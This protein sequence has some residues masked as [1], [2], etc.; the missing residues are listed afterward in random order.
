M[1]K[2]RRQSQPVVAMCADT[3]TPERTHEV[4]LNAMSETVVCHDTAMTIAWANRAAG[5]SAGVAAEEL[6]GRK[7]YEVW[8]QRATPCDA[9][10][11]VRVL[12]TGKPAQGETRSPDGRSWS[13]HGSPLC[14]AQG[15]IIGA[16][17]LAQDSTARTTLA[18]ALR[19]SEERFHTLVE[20]T[21]DV[22]W[23]LDAAGMYTYINAPG[24][25]NSGY[26]REE[27]IGKTPVDFMPPVEAQR[28][29]TIFR[30][31]MNRRKSFTLLRSTLR[32]KDGHLLEIETNGTP[33]FNVHGVY[34]GYRGVS[35]DVTARVRAEDAL[36]ASEARYR[37][38]VEL[39]PEA[40]LQINAEGTII[41]ANRQIPAGQGGGPGHA[42][43]GR[44]LLVR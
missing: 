3:L 33:V 12:Q 44:N 5:A 42:Q 14:D 31:I 19:E 27:F 1:P 35:R 41:S 22:I 24:L 10:P 43:Q 16:I 2:R 25:A 13:V 9:C 40:I 29:G 4:I 32:H 20:K 26:K 34:V 15:R 17:E 23:E 38:L 30:D 18:D 7:C 37:A 6:V 36:R 11:I 28:V 21:N 8:H 39:S